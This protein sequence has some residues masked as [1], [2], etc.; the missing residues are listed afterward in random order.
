MILQPGTLDVNI[1]SLPVWSTQEEFSD[2]LLIY[3][4]L[5]PEGI[6]ILT[7]RVRETER[8]REIIP[9]ETYFTYSFSS[10]QPSSLF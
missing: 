1:S 3:M 7:K 6:G 10:L 2:S 8:E 5:E 4:F 9:K